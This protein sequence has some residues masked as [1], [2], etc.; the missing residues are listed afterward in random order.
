MREG[1]NSSERQVRAMR[2]TERFTT[3][4]AVFLQQLDLLEKLIRSE[5]KDDA[6]C[7]VAAVVR[8]PV[9]KHAR[10]EEELLFPELEPVL[11]R[12]E[13]PLAVLYSDHEQIKCLLESIAAATNGQLRKLC[14]S[15]IRLLRDH[16]ARED[17][18]VF[19]FAEQVA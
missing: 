1:A 16:I 10:E 19:P 13:G 6:I 18:V 14:E 3:E 12:E 7:A 5:A 15:F 4:H 8:A 2:L 9:E 11:G 17:D